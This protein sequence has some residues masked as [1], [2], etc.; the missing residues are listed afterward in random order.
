VEEEVEETKSVALI[1][2]IKEKDELESDSFDPINIH[3]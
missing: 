2:A 1:A 3:P